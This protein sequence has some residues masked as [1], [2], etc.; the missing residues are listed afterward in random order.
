MV[1]LM[2][3]NN[4]PH[5]DIANAIEEHGVRVTERNVSNWKTRG[6]Y[7]DWRLEQERIITTRLR[8]DNLTDYLRPTDA[9]HLPEVGL[10]L[11][12]TQLCEFLLNPQT[13]QQLTSDPE[14]FARTI[15]NLCRV[16]RHLH[17]LQKYRDDSARELGYKHNPERVKR[18]TDQRLETT[19][20][21]YSAEK[22]S[23]TDDEP[24]I[25]HRNFIPK[26]AHSNVAHDDSDQNRPAVDPLSLLSAMTSALKNARSSK[27]AA[28]NPISAS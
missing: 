10:Q 25:P 12:A 3:Q 23:E 4:I 15:S 21:I 28:S 14:K 9:T 18:E 6:G 26:N 8:Q 22:L 7:D 1:N 24:D 11:T 17:L 19:R 27:P 2:L 20:H 13:Q 16:T 5:V